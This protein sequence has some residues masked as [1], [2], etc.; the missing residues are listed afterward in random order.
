MSYTPPSMVP[1]M[2]RGRTDKRVFD[3]KTG[4]YYRPDPSAAMM[5]ASILAQWKASG[6]AAVSLPIWS[7]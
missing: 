2:F 6:Q 3:P 7:E 5:A 1:R 4:R